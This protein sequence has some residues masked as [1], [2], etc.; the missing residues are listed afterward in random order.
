MDFMNPGYIDG[1]GAY[2]RQHGIRLDA[3]WSVRADWM[4]ERPAW[5]GVLVNLVDMETA[6]LRACGRRTCDYQWCT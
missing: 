4:P 3:R 1:A 6:Y 2:A 5:E